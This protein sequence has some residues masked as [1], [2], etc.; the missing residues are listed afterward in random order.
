MVDGYIQFGTRSPAIVVI[1]MLENKN[2]ILP[3]T[4]IATLCMEK[5]V[6]WF[7]L[8]KVK[9]HFV[10]TQFWIVCLCGTTIASMFT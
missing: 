6:W 10:N 4:I 3:L 2:F 1:F 7:K 5:Y 8:V 9:L